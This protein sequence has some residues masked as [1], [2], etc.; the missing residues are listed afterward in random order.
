MITIK[1]ISDRLGLSQTTVSNVVRGKTS[2][3]SPK[4]V[5]RVQAALE[6]YHYVPNMSA[7][8][9]AQKSSR[10]I[11]MILRY[12]AQKDENPL[13]DPF[14]G[15]LLGG[16]EAAVR[17][18]GYFLL[19][20]AASSIGEVLHLIETWNID[21]LVLVGF[22]EGENLQISS[23]TKK[24]LV[25][26][27]C[28]FGP[29]AP[30]YSNV[31]LDD[32]AAARRMTEYLIAK[33]HRGLAFLADNRVGVDAQRWAGFCDALAA[34]GLPCGEEHFVP[35]AAEPEALPQSLAALPARRGALTA[36]LFAS[37]YYAVRGIHFLQDHGCTVPGD[38]SVAGF[39]D[40]L[41]ARHTRPRL[42][43]ILQDPT[44]KGKAAC[45]MLLDR[46][47]HKTPAGQH[48]VLETTLVERDS[49]APLAP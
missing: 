22:H 10:I 46:I 16:V 20:S 38:F 17:A 43:T 12:N 2:E 8:T 27:D 3:V 47:K 32:R 6:Q 31:G 30:A 26:I 29:D 34:A 9:L 45:A 5:A 1:E 33:G 25:F 13:R 42:T 7:R 28:Y 24:P 40:N 23:Q 35:L 21:G 19:V 15:E 44:A 48:L 14:A 37:D 11:G 18:A 4:T 49:V 41:L 39:D 36:L